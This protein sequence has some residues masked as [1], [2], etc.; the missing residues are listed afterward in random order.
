MLCII[1]WDRT[2]EMEFPW[3]FWKQMIGTLG[4]TKRGKKNIYVYEHIISK[5]KRTK[6][7]IQMQIVLASNC[8][9]VNADS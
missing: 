4:W 3:E 9:E 5:R 2:S 7:K 1:F 8:F 6:N